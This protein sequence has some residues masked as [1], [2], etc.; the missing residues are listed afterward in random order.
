MAAVLP[1]CEPSSCDG[2][3][4]GV[5][6]LHGLTGN[7]ASMRPL[8]EHLAGEG[9]AIEMPLLPGHGTSD[10]RDLATSSWQEVA[11]QTVESFERLRARTRLQIVAGLSGGA[12]VALGLA[13]GR[14]EDVAGLVLINPSYDYV[15]Q[16][17]QFR[18]LPLLKWTPLSAKGIGNDIAKPGQEE[19]PAERYPLKTLAD[20]LRIQQSA[21]RTLHKVVAPTLVLTSRQDHVV[22]PGD[23][24]NI[25]DRISSTDVEHV[26]LERS[27][28]VATLDYDAELIQELTSK[29]ISRVAGG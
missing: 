21:K 2:G 8:A 12:V 28:H 10:W 19:Y 17:P 26:W 24:A 7:P 25:I 23:S 14:P 9:H 1:Q 3:D 29:F 16:N 13:G 18:L 11:R 22:D 27:Y 5:L 15:A 20:L 4:V 6:V